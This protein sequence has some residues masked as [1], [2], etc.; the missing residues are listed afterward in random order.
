M[1]QTTNTLRLGRFIKEYKSSGAS[2]RTLIVVTLVCVLIASI[3]FLG[4]F[5]E[6]QSREWGGVVALSIIGCLF[7]LPVFAGV[8]VSFRGRGANLT[9]YEH[10]LSFRRGGRESTTTW[11]EIDSYM[12]EAACRITKKDGE[13]IEFGQGLSDAAEIAQKIQEE[14]LSLMLPRVRAAI[15]NGS[16]V[17]YKG[18][19]S[20][21]KFPLGKGFSNYME[22]HS[23]FTVDA[24]GIT[25]KDGGS[26]ILWRDITDFG[27]SEETRGP[28][29]QIPIS[30]LYISDPLQSFRTRY[31]LLSNA[32]VLL[33]LC[34]AMTSPAGR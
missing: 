8:Y 1:N 21:D 15:R 24:N 33:A 3:F 2:L 34:A 20:V 29:I 9:L 30:L 6:A 10:G 12:Q 28:R 32:H 18:W 25:E 26:R 13:V 4:A 14:T 22:A 5:S 19:Q 16:S 23:G 11:D 31:G 17:E 7:L 27:I